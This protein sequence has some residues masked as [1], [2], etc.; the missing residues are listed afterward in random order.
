M[1][2]LKCSNFFFFLNYCVDQYNTNK[3]QPY[4]VFNLNKESNEFHYKSPLEDGVAYKGVRVNFIS[5]TI[6]ETKAYMVQSN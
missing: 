4:V 6:M 2:F 5:L 3:K 1:L